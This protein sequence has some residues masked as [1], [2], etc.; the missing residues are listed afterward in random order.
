MEGIS[1]NTHVL[2]DFRLR[3]ETQASINCLTFTVPTYKA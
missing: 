3:S 1:E 2:Y